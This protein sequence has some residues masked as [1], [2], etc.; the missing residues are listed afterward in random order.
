[1]T[2]LE[3]EEKEE[4][5]KGNVISGEELKRAAEEANK[6]AAEPEKNKDRIIELER[7]ILASSNDKKVKE[8]AQ[9]II[10]KL[11]PKK[12][13]SVKEELRIFMSRIISEDDTNNIQDLTQQIV[14]ALDNVNF[15]DEEK[16]GVKGID[17]VDVLK[18]I[19]KISD[20][21]KTLNNKYIDAVISLYKSIDEMGDKKKGVLSIAE[22]SSNFKKINLKYNIPSEEIAVISCIISLLTNY[23]DIFTKT[24]STLPKGPLDNSIVKGA[25]AYDQEVFERFYTKGSNGYE[26]KKE[27]EPINNI[28]RAFDGYVFDEKLAKCFKTYQDAKKT[29]EDLKNGK[30]PEGAKNIRD[31]L[32]NETEAEKAKAEL[33]NSIDKTND[34]VRELNSD[35]EKLNEIRAQAEKENDPITNSII[36]KR[37]FYIFDIDKLK[38]DTVEKPEEVEDFLDNLKKEAERLI[39]E[40]SS[41]LESYAPKAEHSKDDLKIEESVTKKIMTKSG[42]V[43]KENYERSYE[44]DSGKINKYIESS[45]TN[46][47]RLVDNYRSELLKIANAMIAE[48]NYKKMV[49]LRLKFDNAVTDLG[50]KLT[51]EV[52]KA[53]EKSHEKLKY[54]K[55]DKEIDD[56]KKHKSLD[57]KGQESLDIANIKKIINSAFTKD[58]QNLAKIMLINLLTKFNDSKEIVDRLNAKS[59]EGFF[60]EGIIYAGNTGSIYAIDPDKITEKEIKDGKYYV[61]DQTRARIYKN[62]KDLLNS[63]GINVNSLTVDVMKEVKKSLINDA[64]NNKKS[65]DEY[66]NSAKEMFNYVKGIQGNSSMMTEGIGDVLGKIRDKGAEAVNNIKQ[67]VKDGINKQKEDFHT[68]DVKQDENTNEFVGNQELK[69]NT[70]DEHGTNSN[71]NSL[72]ELLA[73][74]TKKIGTIE[75]HFEPKGTGMDDIIFRQFFKGFV[76]FKTATANYIA[77]TE[78]LKE[79]EKMINLIGVRTDE[80]INRDMTQRTT[81]AEHYDALNNG[82][83][84]TSSVVTSN[85]ADSTYGDGYN[86]KRLKEMNKKLNSTTYTY[87]PNSKTKIVRRTFD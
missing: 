36:Q 86:S 42:F 81:E 84:P 64:N 30:I 23:K 28:L 51:K 50:Y 38:A 20:K 83:T 47:G 11:S 35:T 33:D 21:I 79:L 85:A 24:K 66:I 22:V 54:M 2:I 63:V 44:K 69:Q 49:A 65:A 4:E 46:I 72:D 62:P 12:D 77:R 82:G 27:C 43:L 13:E 61:F 73:A 41:K 70:T 17:L 19:E 18:V 67:K 8:M 7:K 3:S 32:P 10:D 68:T 55:L 39:G 48:N 75:K 31:S 26:L 15:G 58:H 76:L 25:N 37:K 87:S 16:T 59:F 71:Y 80:Q 56:A 34:A 57:Q 78:N 74:N 9:K 53:T 45:K 52:Q 60:D 5:K 1:M 14:D 6:L 40:I 29:I